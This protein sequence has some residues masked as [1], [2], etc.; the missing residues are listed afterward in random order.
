MIGQGFPGL[1]CTPALDL[2]EKDD[3]TDED[4]DAELAAAKQ[5]ATTKSGRLLARSFGFRSKK[6]LQ[7]T[8]AVEEE[9]EDEAPKP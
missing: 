4:L 2:Q 8:A 1:I 5:A 7:P 9:D 6:A 3:P